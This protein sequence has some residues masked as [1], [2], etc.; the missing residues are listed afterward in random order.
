VEVYVDNEGNYCR[1][2]HKGEF[3][4]MCGV[5]NMG[6]IITDKELVEKD[7][8]PNLKKMLCVDNFSTEKKGRPFEAQWWFSNGSS[9]D[10]MTT[11]QNPKQFEGVNLQWTWCNEPPPEAI[12]KAALGRFKLGGTLFISATILG[13]AWILDEI[14]ESDNPAYKTVTMDIDENRKSLGGY[15]PDEA[16]DRML[17]SQDP[18][19]REAR[20]SGKALML[21]GRVFKKYKHE[22]EGAHVQDVPPHAPAAD[23][24]NDY[25]VI[26]AT[27]P[28]DKIPNYS[29]WAYKKDGKVVIFREHP[30]EDFWEYSDNPWADPDELAAEYKRLEAGDQRE[31]TVRL[32]DKKFGSSAKFGE[33]L[34]VQEVLERSGLQYELW[35]GSSRG[36]VNGLIGRYLEQDR[37]VISKACKNMDKALQRH[38]FLEQSS[39]RAKDEKGQ[40]QD[41][42]EKTRHPIDV[43]G[44]LLEEFER[45]AGHAPLVDYGGERYKSEDEQLNDK[46]WGDR[47]VFDRADYER[48]KDEDD[49][50]IIAIEF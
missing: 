45:N 42:D 50:D 26:M 1:R 32:L 9:F 16:V 6:R 21:A 24:E 37:L 19:E 33:K 36:A 3:L 20:K 11:D 12:F 46:I 35:D 43:L 15:L 5:P 4:D 10:I 49:F 14:I 2:Y 38:R 41:V 13:C 34:T 23:D 29:A 7:V 44:A 25:N 31:P 22:G 28:H 18:N 30:T 17:A 40:R 27:D 48:D 47:L 39:A 8:I